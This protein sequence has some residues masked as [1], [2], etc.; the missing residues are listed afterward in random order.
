MSSL[1][2]P[3]NVGSKCGGIFFM[4]NKN[5]VWCNASKSTLE[6]TKLWVLAF[7][8][9]DLLQAK[10]HLRIAY[11]CIYFHRSIWC[12]LAQTSS[13]TGLTVGPI[14][15]GNSCA[16]VSPLMKIYSKIAVNRLS[17]NLVFWETAFSAGTAVKFDKITTVCLNGSIA[18]ALQLTLD[19]L[20]AG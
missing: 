2:E 17:R 19:Y 11:L 5:L 14:Q 20:I 7:K 10:L 6:K 16:A 13:W 18:V 12:W 9:N 1:L 15:S 8:Q 3:G 4:T